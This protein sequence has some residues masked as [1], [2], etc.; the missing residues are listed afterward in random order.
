MFVKVQSEVQNEVQSEV[1][2][3]YLDS[4]KFGQR[5]SKDTNKNNSFVQSLTLPKIKISQINHGKEDRFEYVQYHY[6]LSAFFE[7]YN[8]PK[9]DSA[10]LVK[11]LKKYIMFPDK[12]LVASYSTFNLLVH[13][14]NNLDL[15]AFQEETNNFEIIYNDGFRRKYKLFNKLWFDISKCDDEVFE[16]KIISVK[17]KKFNESRC[18]TPTRQ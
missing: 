1:Q 5:L 12:P 13:I 16:T 18:W 11:N 2:S 3:E 4:P 8:I 15:I 6:T 10:L 9:L 14:F 17:V 7:F